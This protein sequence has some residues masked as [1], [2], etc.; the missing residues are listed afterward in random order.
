MVLLQSIITSFISFYYSKCIQFTSKATRFTT[1]TM[2]KVITFVIKLFK[3]L[4]AAAI[5][6]AFE[7]ANYFQ[8]RHA[9]RVSMV[10]YTARYNGTVGRLS[11]VATQ[12]I[13]A[14]NGRIRSC[15]CYGTKVKRVLQHT[16]LI[17]MNNKDQSMSIK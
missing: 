6:D 11:M 8:N 2:S 3:I 14:L 13:D 10:V 17:W 9:K 15:H 5:E 16:H 12:M 7:L 1:V 4:L